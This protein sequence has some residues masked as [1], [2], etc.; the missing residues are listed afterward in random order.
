MYNS[1]KTTILN[2]QS[3]QK[4]E[5][6]QN[7]YTCNLYTCLL[8]NVTSWQTIFPDQQTHMQEEIGTDLPRNSGTEF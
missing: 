2:L 7:L 5:I 8:F 1:K 3:V 6:S 4:G